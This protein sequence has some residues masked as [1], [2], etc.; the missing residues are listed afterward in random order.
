MYCQQY[1]ILNV[2]PLISYLTVLLPIPYLTVLPWIPSLNVLSPIPHP[3]SFAIN[4]SSI[5]YC[6]KYLIHKVLPLIP[7][8]WSIATKYHILKVLSPI[9]HTLSLRYWHIFIFFLYYLS[10]AKWQKFYP[11]LN[12]WKYM[13]EASSLVLVMAFKEEGLNLA[14][15]IAN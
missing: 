15:N 10:N 5:T 6:P 3:Y 14:K 8:P 1:L 7:Y 12:Y 4:T 9:P 11:T 13:Y 2:S